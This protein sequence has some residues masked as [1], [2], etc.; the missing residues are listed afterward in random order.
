[1]SF[2]EVKLT[3]PSASQAVLQKMS[4]LQS[5]MP[6]AIKRGLDSGLQFAVGRIKTDRLSGQGPYDPSEHRLGERSGVLRSSLIANPAVIS[7][8][9]VTGSIDV[10]TPYAYTHEYGAT[11][12]A[13]NAPF[14]VFKIEGKWIRTKKVVIPERAPFRTG[15]Q[16]N[17]KTIQEDISHEWEQLFK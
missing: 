16:E 4:G 5:E 14:L 15:L 7:G 17:L 12:T 8:N 1:M 13:R 6:K 9:T 11:I 3:V 2:L 10:G